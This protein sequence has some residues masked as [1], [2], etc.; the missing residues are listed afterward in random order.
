VLNVSASWV[1][2]NLSAHDRHQQVTSSQE[3][4]DSYT[5][6]KELFCHHLVTG[7]KTLIYHWDSLSKLEFMQWKD[8]DCPSFTEIY[9][10]TINW[11]DD[12]NSF[13]GMQMD[14]L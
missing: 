7:D 3:L 8:V 9:N 12:G 5:S 2:Q 4:L 14:C 10:S 6:D 1:S 11:L 13:S